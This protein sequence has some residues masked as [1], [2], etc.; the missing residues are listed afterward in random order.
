MEPFGTGLVFTR[1]RSGLGPEPFK[2]DPNLDLQT[3]RSSFGSFYYHSGPVPERSVNRIQ[4]DPIKF[5]DWINLESTPCKHSLSFVNQGIPAIPGSSGAF[6]Y[7][8]IAS[9][10]HLTFISAQEWGV[11][12]SRD[13]HQRS[14]DFWILG[15]LA[16]FNV[17][18]S[19]TKKT[20]EPSIRFWSEIPIGFPSIYPSLGSCRVFWINMYVQC[21]LRLGDKSHRFH[22]PQHFHEPTMLQ[23]SPPAAIT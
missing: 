15:I 9:G 17:T 3:S 10:G 8:A 18:S 6:P 21:C 19:L 5:S 2:M 7:A 16:S 12:S 1:D 20:F 14:R 23:E 22:T 11:N 13:I 4:L